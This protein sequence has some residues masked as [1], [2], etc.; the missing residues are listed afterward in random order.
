MAGRPPVPVTEPCQWQN[1]WWATVAVE[2]FDAEVAGCRP[3]DLLTWA[4]HAGVRVGDA[5]LLVTTA[6][7]RRL[8]AWGWAVGAPVGDEAQGWRV[9][10][11]FGG[12]L[13]EPP[14]LRALRHDPA[15]AVWTPLARVTAGRLEGIPPAVWQVLREHL[16]AQVA[17]ARAVT[18]EAGPLAIEVPPPA[19]STYGDPPPI[20][21]W[22]GLGRAAFFEALVR[23][24]LLPEGFTLVALQP[25]RDAAGI[26]VVAH[27]PEVR[28]TRWVA[29]LD[30]TGE[31]VPAAAVHEVHRGCQAHGA[32]RGLLVAT[33]PVSAATRA[34]AQELHVDVWDA[35]RLRSAWLRATDGHG[36]VVDGSGRALPV[37]ERR[38][39][40]I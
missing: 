7:D 30:L 1:A 28:W 19:V 8:R 9:T 37:I 34:L 16:G 25:G 4:A 39:M 2:R 31:P 17:E 13:D 33:G 40:A 27:R 15:L 11:R 3:G 22:D 12:L 18:P 20:G 23:R 21:P 26:D 36:W 32:Q 5:Y 38:V 6:P 10:V 35:V 24:V 29:Q 14:C